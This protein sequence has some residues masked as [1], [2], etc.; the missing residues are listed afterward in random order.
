MELDSIVRC[1]VEGLGLDGADFEIGIR[2][3]WRCVKDTPRIHIRHGVT[4]EQVGPELDAVAVSP[5]GVVF[6]Q[7]GG[8]FGNFGF[9]LAD[10]RLQFFDVLALAGLDAGWASFHGFTVSGCR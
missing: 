3:G 2:E 9:Q 4:F 1:E 5:A 8:Q 10:L 7:L 6:G